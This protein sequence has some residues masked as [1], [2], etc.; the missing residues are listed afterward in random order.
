[1]RDGRF[2]VIHAPRPELYDLERDPFEREN[3]YDQRRETAAALHGKLRAMRTDRPAAQ[4]AS[5]EW[6]GRLG[7]L[8]YVG[9]SAVS[10]MPRG[11][12]APDPKDCIG[13][14]HSDG[15]RSRAECGTSRPHRDRAEPSRFQRE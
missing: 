15:T 1:L 7:A 4:P 9:A 10:A 5:N 14:Q 13:M 8:G 11:G 3:I 12:S 6:R 2:K